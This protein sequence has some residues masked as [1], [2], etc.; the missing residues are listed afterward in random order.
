M[1]FN[2]ECLRRGPVALAI[3]TSLLSACATVSSDPVV[4]VCPPVMEYSHSEQALVATEIETL[5]E[6]AILVSWLADYS[7][8]RE[9]ANAC[10][11]GYDREIMW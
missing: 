9:Q 10:G 1:K 11:P 4:G 5:P 7:L 2:A 8:L 6:S 3:V